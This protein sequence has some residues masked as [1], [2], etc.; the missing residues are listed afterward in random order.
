[1]SL[2]LQL[3]NYIKLTRKT[4]TRGLVNCNCVVFPNWMNPV[5][6]LRSTPLQLQ[7]NNPDCLVQPSD[8]CCYLCVGRTWCPYCA[9]RA[10][11]GN[12]NS[13]RRP[14]VTAYVI[15]KLILLRGCSHLLVFR[16]APKC[17]ASIKTVS[18]AINATCE[19]LPAV[20]P[21]PPRRDSV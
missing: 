10:S 21:L 6:C 1:M 5:G 13:P 18:C 19:L 3:A 17:H 16:Q 2:K 7:L 20:I 14:R 8:S 4:K 12:M 9:Q 15:L 11:V